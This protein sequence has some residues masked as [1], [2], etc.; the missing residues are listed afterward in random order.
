MAE[1]VMRMSDNEPHSAPT[2]A[3]AGAQKNAATR[4]E[5]LSKSDL[6]CM[7]PRFGRS[8]ENVRLHTDSKAQ[9]QATELGAKAFTHGSDISFAPG[10]SPNDKKLLAH[11]LTHVAQQ[12]QR[13]P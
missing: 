4:G 12:D 6:D 9:R 13:S 7:E 8:F 11:E 2:N 3:T 5:A 1:K 10:S